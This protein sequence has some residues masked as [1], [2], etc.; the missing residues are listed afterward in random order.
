MDTVI[1]KP[2]L[3]KTSKDQQNSIISEKRS[4]SSPKINRF[5]QRNISPKPSSVIIENINYQNIYCLHKK[6]F[7]V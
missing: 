2:N 7:A 1:L 6:N 5:H 4:V 3:I